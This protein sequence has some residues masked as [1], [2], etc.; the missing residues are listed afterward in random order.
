[1]WEGAREGDAAGEGVLRSSSGVE[2]PV[3]PGGEVER[4]GGACGRRLFCAGRSL[5]RL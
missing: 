2:E 1:M 4:S 5:G 3:G